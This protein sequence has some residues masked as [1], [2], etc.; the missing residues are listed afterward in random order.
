MNCYGANCPTKTRSHFVLEHSPSV[1]WMECLLITL[2]K[3]PTGRWWM[4][5]IKV[6]VAYSRLIPVV[7]EI[8][9][10]INPGNTDQIVLV[11]S[12]QV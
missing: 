6:I 9:M 2:L 3:V 5:S 4:L 11:P 7:V 12:M 8:H 1:K 10:G